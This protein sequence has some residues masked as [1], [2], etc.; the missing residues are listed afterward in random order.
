MDYWFCEV[1]AH[2]GDP[3][4]WDY[5]VGKQRPGIYRCWN[6]GAEATKAELKEHTDA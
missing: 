6:C 5:R 3:H 2:I 1:G 4:T